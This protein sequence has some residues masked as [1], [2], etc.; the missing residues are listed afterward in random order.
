MKI[1]RL[2]ARFKS[3][4]ILKGETSD[5]SPDR[6]HFY[7]SLIKGE[8]MQEGS[9]ALKTVQIALEDLKA[10]FIVKDFNGN[11]HYHETYNDSF[12]WCEKKVKVL[13]FDGEEVVGYASHFSI[14]HNGFF[15]TP[16]DRQC[17]N[18]QIYV[19]KSATSKITFL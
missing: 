8:I 11:K 2:V 17:N 6:A 12:P 5:F 10:A 4:N 19:V 7:L 13:F 15:M 9:V 3:G 14:G 18:K 1:D 16:A